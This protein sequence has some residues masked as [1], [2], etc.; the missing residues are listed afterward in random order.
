MTKAYTRCIILFASALI[1]SVNHFAMAAQ[2]CSTTIPAT[3]PDGQLIE[4]GD[5]TVT[6]TKTGLM[7][8]QQSEKID[9]SDNYPG[10]FSWE[11]AIK[12]AMSSNYAGHT[13]WRVPNSKELL[14]LVEWRCNY[15]AINLQYF[16]EHGTTLSSEDQTY[17]TADRTIDQCY[18]YD[19]STYTLI[20]CYGGM[21]VVS[22]NIV[23][24]SQ[25][26]SY[27][28]RHLRLVRNAN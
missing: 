24:I 17:V 9:L 23:R 5:G 6:D 25:E 14:S 3:I 4:N 21:T 19:G 8:K 20:P 11:D 13:D 12:K 28:P 7:W 22:F 18:D 26:P 16:P 1:S 2:F 15:P 10:S 27:F